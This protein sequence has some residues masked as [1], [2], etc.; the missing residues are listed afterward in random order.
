MRVHL[1]ENVFRNRGL[2]GVN[3]GAHNSQGDFRGV[4]GGGFWILQRH[5][6]FVDT[7]LGGGVAGGGNKLYAGVIWVW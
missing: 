4:P 1:G 5:H 7:F 6:E 3:V 2:T